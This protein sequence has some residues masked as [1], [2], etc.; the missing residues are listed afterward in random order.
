MLALGFVALGVVGVRAASERRSAARA[1][2]SEATPLLV[3]A[4]ELYVALADADAAASTGFLGLGPEPAD[5]RARYLGDIERAGDRLASIAGQ[6]ALSANGRGSVAAI[7]RG[8][9]IYTS[10]VEAARINTRLEYPVG[11]AY[12]RRASDSMRNEMLPAATQVYREAA[13]ELYAAYRNGTS[14]TGS[15]GVLV[16]GSAL[17]GLL[18]LVQVFVSVRTRRLVNLGLLGATMLVVAPGVWAG[19]TLDAQEKSLLRSRREGS[20]Q[21]IVLS[22]ARILALQSLSAENLFLIE[23][24][25]DQSHLEHFKQVTASIGAPD[26]STGLLRTAARLA[27]RTGSAEAVD[28]IAQRY[29]DYLAV[30]AGVRKLHDADKY[31]SAVELAV[32]DEAGAAS[33]L[34]EALQSEIDAARQ[35]L[36]SN[37]ADAH[38]RL[39]GLAAMVASSAVLAAALA[40][41]GL[42][43]RSREYR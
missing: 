13:R 36:D 32:Q 20:D 16:I 35:R 5:L 14:H 4:E 21:L 30:H 31:L 42:Q 34:D 27:E 41:V 37:A 19:L 29:A 25:T 39:S 40:L 1:V 3:R 8:L 33:L 18:L 6:R 10:Q 9:P 43:R 23:R 11:A 24:G 38:E 7:A 26:A 15:S 17:V 12:L 2:G 28:Q 22:T